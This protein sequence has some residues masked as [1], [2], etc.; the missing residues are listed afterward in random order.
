MR[1]G[2]FGFEKFDTTHPLDDKAQNKVNLFQMFALK[3]RR[4]V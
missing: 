3:R 1:A 4:N 2:I